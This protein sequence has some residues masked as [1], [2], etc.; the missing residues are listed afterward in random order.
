VCGKGKE[1][2]TLSRLLPYL[3]CA[4]AVIPPFVATTP[5][6]H[7]Y[8]FHLAQIDI[9]TRHSSSTYLQEHYART[10]L[11]LPNILIDVIGVALASYLPIDLAGRLLVAIILL[12][13]VSGVFALHRALWRRASPWPMVTL[14][15]VFN[16]VFLMGFVNYL[17]GV[18]VSLWALAVRQWISQRAWWRLSAGVVGALAVYFA[19]IAAFGLYGLVLATFAFAELRDRPLREWVSRCVVD[20]VP[21]VMAAGL[22]LTSATSG[23]GGLQLF[24]GLQPYLHW[25]AKWLLT[26]FAFGDRTLDAVNAATIGVLA[27]VVL[28]LARLRVRPEFWLLLCTGGLLYFAAPFFALSGAFLDFR[29]PVCL[30]I[31]SLPLI[32]LEPKSRARERVLVALLSAA[33]IVRVGFVAGEWLSTQPALAEM[34][35]TLRCIPDKAVLFTVSEQPAANFVDPWTGWTPPIKHAASLAGLERDVYVPATWAQ[36]GQHPFVSQPKWQ[37]VYDLQGRNPPHVRN[38]AA[39][40]ALLRRFRESVPGFR[41]FVLV[42]DPGGQL[43][44]LAV[45]HRIVRRG[46]R[47]ALIEL[48][49][50]D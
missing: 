35:E 20:V 3:A 25:K 9:L 17:L 30:C 47:H 50:G 34:R 18:G 14:L 27:V 31:L 33:A 23:S 49:P 1:L 46:A 44:M 10:S 28:S 40:D 29:I 22:F 38:V 7:D 19:H 16:S 8:P 15:V 32:D 4:L 45:S 21:F 2:E 11:L 41:S 6:L 39:L 5:P 42:L 24:T 43:D 36:F 26:P 48:L 12:S 37:G 13:Q